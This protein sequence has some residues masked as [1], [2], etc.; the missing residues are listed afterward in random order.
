MWDEGNYKAFAALCIS[1][2]DDLIGE[3]MEFQG[4]LIMDEHGEVEPP[5]TTAAWKR[6][7]ALFFHKGLTSQLMLEREFMALKMEKG[8]TIRTYW[9]RAAK[10]LSS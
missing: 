9:A 8:E 6:L 2:T 4:R 5:N 1:L 7:D 10:L 3:I